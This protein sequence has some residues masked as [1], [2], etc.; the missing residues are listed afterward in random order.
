MNT[1]AY[2]RMGRRQRQHYRQKGE[3]TGYD[4]ETKG[5]LLRTSN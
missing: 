5:S 4:K 2:E 1:L 3:R